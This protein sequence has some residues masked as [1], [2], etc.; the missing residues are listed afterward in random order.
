M[1]SVFVPSYSRRSN[2][3]AQPSGWR[4]RAATNPIPGKRGRRADAPSASSSRQH[5]VTSHRAGR[6]RSRPRSSGSS[7]HSSRVTPRVH[8]FL[9]RGGIGCSR[10]RIA[11]YGVGLRV[12]MPAPFRT[13]AHS[14]HCPGPRPGPRARAP[15]PAP[16]RPTPPRA[17][18]PA[19]VERCAGLRVRVDRQ[20]PTGTNRWPIRNE[21]GR[22]LHM[23]R[24]YSAPARGARGQSTS[25]WRRGDSR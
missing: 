21:P 16:L 1:G 11:W 15:P 5:D 20:G 17:P 23:N 19:G 24:L 14:A 12:H 4:K 9:L 18:R 13:P 2:H 6:K 10:T 25:E 7:S 8:L 22:R 3:S